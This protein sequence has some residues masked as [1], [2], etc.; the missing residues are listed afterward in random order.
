MGWELAWKLASEFQ[1]KPFKVDGIGAGGEGANGPERRRAHRLLYGYLRWRDALQAIIRPCLKRRP[2]PRLEALLLLAAYELAASPA[3]SRPAIVHHAVELAKRHLS[4]GEARLVNALLRR[5]PDL[6][7]DTARLSAEAAHP[8]W[9]VERW[10]QQFDPEATARLLRWNQQEPPLYACWT[11]D[12]SPPDDWKPSPWSGYHDVSA[13][14]WPELRLVLQS[15]RAYIQDPFARHPVELAAPQAGEIVLDGCAAPGGKSR[16]LLRKW[17]GGGRLIACDLPGPRLGRLRE[18]LSVTSGPVQVR[19]FPAD[20]TTLSAEELTAAG[21]PAEF[22]AIVLDVPCSN[23]GVIARRPDVRYH[24]RPEQ[25]ARLAATQSAI[26]GRA[27]AFLRPGGRL[28]YSTC[29]LEPEE[30]SGVIEA[31]LSA[32]PD[33]QL[34]ET[35]LSQPWVDRHDGGGAFLLTRSGG[36]KG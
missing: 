6:D 8:A 26:L 34:V 4:A 24:L 18:N 28:I 36:G 2:R 32:H 13:V 11:A 7:L 27:A 10:Q 31:F 20:L 21:L 35:R 12:G 19:I 16:G 3:S 5:F 15:G 9:L 29:S 33:F 22:D 17:S 1:Q 25:L 23:T 14:P 30:N